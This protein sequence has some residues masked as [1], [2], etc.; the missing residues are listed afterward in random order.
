MSGT[1]KIDFIVVGAQKAGTTALA[2]YLSQHEN[3]DMGKTKEIHFFDNESAFKN[4]E[5]DYSAYHSHFNFDDPEKVYGEATPIYIY[6]EPAA[7]RIWKYNK[8]IKLVAILRNPVERAFSHWNME[9]GR[10]A[11]EETFSLAIRHEAMRCRSSLPDQNRVCSYVDRGFYSEQVRRLRRYFRE[12]QL[13]IAKYESFK[14]NQEQEMY[15]IFE[16]LGV[17]KDAFTYKPLSIHTIKYHQEAMA[18][19]DRNYLVDIFRYDIKEIEKALNW[20]C[21]DWLS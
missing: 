1:K 14:A 5:P 15:N 20:D 16:F 18:E 21:S 13:F 4:E 3:I 19:F 2:Y 11:E 17:D 12:D 7:K 9:V 10:G 6:W 8:D